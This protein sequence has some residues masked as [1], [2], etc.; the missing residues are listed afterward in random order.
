[1]ATSEPNSAVPVPNANDGETIA[2]TLLER[3]PV[4]VYVVD[5]NFR[6]VL[7][8]RELR[9]VS[10]WDT[11]NCRTVDHLLENFYP[12]DAYRA[13]IGAIHRAWGNTPSEQVRDTVMVLTTKDGQQRSISWTTARLRVGTGPVRGYIAVGVDI[14]VRRNLEHWVTLFQQSLLQMNEALAL[15]DPQSNI[16]AWSAGATSLLGHT[17]ADAQGTPLHSLL[18]EDS[19]DTTSQS[20]AAA[21]ATENAAPF[22]AALRTTDGASETLQ[23][24]ISQIAGPGGELLAHLV[25]MSGSAADNSGDP[26]ALEDALRRTE[27]AEAEAEAAKSSLTEAE[28][29]LAEAEDSLAAAEASL[30]KTK[31]ALGEAKA[32]LDEAEIALAAGETRIEIAEDSA[33]ALRAELEQSKADWSVERAELV[34]SH[35]AERDGL[36]EAG[37]EER[38]AFIQR[39]DNERAELEEQLRN[40][41]LAAEERAE[42]QLEAQGNA[43]KRARQEWDDATAIA[44]HEMAGRMTA[45][46]DTIS[47]LL[48]EGAD[49]SGSLPAA[50]VSQ[51][52]QLIG[53]PAMVLTQD[54]ESPSTHFD[55]SAD[56]L[57]LDDE[58]EEAIDAPPPVSPAMVATASEL[59]A[60]VPAGREDGESEL[61][62]DPA[63]ELDLEPIPALDLE[64]ESELDLE[65]ESELDLEPESELDLEPVSELD[66]APIPGLDEVGSSDDDLELEL[67]LEPTEDELGDKSDSE[68]ESK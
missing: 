32:A 24:E 6:V 44:A 2:R 16:L 39:M 53:G 36:V 68:P 18:D 13:P 11:S 46:T 26:L 5:L 37:A 38:A 10:G 52:A 48:I 12:D 8:N 21:L 34:R 58:G 29:S 57:V 49:P 55:L 20:L 19:D 47:Q 17:E 64:P 40:D 56:D 14:T 9:D 41:I 67:E 28:G 60:H 59:E 1:M 63:S 7:M 3:A 61:D 22:S 43:H 15:V 51:L 50:T 4:L 23:L 31:G 65:P 42:E 25:Q 27:E 30:E 45:I 54:E 66:V 35:V 62:L 33:E